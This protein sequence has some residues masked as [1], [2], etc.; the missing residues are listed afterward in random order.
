M[1]WKQGIMQ[2]NN[3]GAASVPGRRFIEINGH[4]YSL[5]LKYFPLGECYAK[6]PCANLE[7]GNCAWG[8]HPNIKGNFHL[9][10][11]STNRS[12]P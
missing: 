1:S 5:P 11:G 2:H 6:S 3:Q 8:G 4:D 7:W 12:F 10:E 9:G